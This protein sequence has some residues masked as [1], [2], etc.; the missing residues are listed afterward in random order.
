M[1]ENRN[2]LLGKG[3]RLTEPVLPAG[4]KVS[5]DA[6]YTFEEARDRLKPMVESAINRMSDLPA[7]AKPGNQVVASILLNPEYIAKSYYP[8]SILKAYGLRAVGSKPARIKPE[9]RSFDREPTEKPTSELFVA[10][11]VSSFRRFLTDLESSAISQAVQ[12]DLPALEKLDAVNPESKIKGS[13]TP[14]DGN[15][16]PLE[17]VLHASE[18]RSDLHII[19]AFQDYL[20]TMG[21]QADLEHRFHAGG[22][23]FLRMRAPLHQI[24]EIAKFSFL[25]A[26]REMPRLRDLS[27]LKSLASGQKL[28][29]ELPIVDAL[30]PNIRV[31]IFDGGI[32]ENSDLEPWVNRF[33]PP[34]IGPAVQEALDH[35]YAVTSAT[36]FGHLKPGETAPRPYA[37]IDHIRVWDVN[38]G[39]DRLQ[40]FDVLER[41]RNTLQTSPKYDFMN[42]SLGP[43]LPIDDDDVHAWTTV[44]DEYLADGLCLST[45]AVG[46]DG[47]ADA[48]LKLNRIQVPADTVN[49]LAIGACDN[50][51]DDWARAEYSSIGPGRS[52]GIVKPDV[53]SFGGCPANP[54]YVLDPQG[55]LLIA[56]SGTSFAAPNALRVGVGVK[57][58]FGTSLDPLAIRTLLIHTAETSSAPQSEIGW[59][60]VRENLDDIVICP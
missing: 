25:R 33:D 22:L 48:A 45:I 56:Q 51:N 28:N 35:G 57:A 47:K 19:G 39:Q 43:R 52:P 42:L 36:L 10:G 41:I 37:K 53:V 50:F 54:Y 18:F 6:P 31:A 30:D 14:T 16:V 40:L 32:P 9:K 49:G 3:E 11:P 34:G 38:S 15:I 20:K 2:F 46:N 24:D 8:E 58:T 13:P 23:C 29:V 5:R 44:L 27:P 26:I 4:R 21:L 7:A 17:V 12:V 59:G 55:L 60:R 1:A